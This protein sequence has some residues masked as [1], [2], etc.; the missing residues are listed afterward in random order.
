VDTTGDPAALG[1]ALDMVI[2]AGRV[3]A[4]GMSGGAAPVRSG[5][6]P[7]KEVDVLGS[8]CC[9]AEDFAMAVALVRR[10]AAAVTRLI[11]DRFP[12][13]EAAA[14]IA[15]AMSRSREVM[16]VTVAAGPS[17]ARLKG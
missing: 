14:A 7:V 1:H 15:R 5:L 12:L 6:L 8:S 4:V 10:A 11:T 16:K 17:R 2:S 9:D 3:V 13:D